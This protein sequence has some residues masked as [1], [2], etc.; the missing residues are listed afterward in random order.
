MMEWVGGDRRGN[1]EEGGIPVRVRQDRTTLRIPTCLAFHRR[2]ADLLRRDVQ[3]SSMIDDH[4]PRGAAAALL[5]GYKSKFLVYLYVPRLPVQQP[6]AATLKRML[7]RMRSASELSVARAQQQR[8][9][10][11]LVIGFAGLFLLVPWNNRLLQY[12]RKFL[13]G[14]LQPSFHLCIP[15]G[16]QLSLVRTHSYCFASHSPHSKH[17]PNLGPI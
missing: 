8:Q 7:S 6:H 2:C 10:Q 3:S 9:Q 1:G 4:S 14:S 11:H 16:E 13:E 17:E 5:A 15:A 12:I